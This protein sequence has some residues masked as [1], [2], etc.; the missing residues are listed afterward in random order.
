MEM[1]SICNYSN[2]VQYSLTKLKRY[3]ETQYNLGKYLHD[4]DIYFQEILYTISEL[5]VTDN[6]WWPV[7]GRLDKKK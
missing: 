5:H 1:S 6:L 4:G 7:L 3:E 2:T